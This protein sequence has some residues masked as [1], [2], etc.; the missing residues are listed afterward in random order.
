MPINR[1]F[2]ETDNSTY[3][4]NDIYNKAA[5]LKSLQLDDLKIKLFENYKAVFNAK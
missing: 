5:Q 4:I 3:S 2:L 1:L